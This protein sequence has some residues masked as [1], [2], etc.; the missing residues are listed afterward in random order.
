MVWGRISGFR[1][2]DEIYDHD[3][4]DKPGVYLFYRRLT[5]SVRYVGRSDSQIYTR[6][7]R[8]DYRF[9]RYKYCYDAEEAYYWECEYFHYFNDTIDN[10][11][12][13]ARPRYSDISCHWC[14]R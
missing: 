6:I 14:G 10:D 4:E 3:I 5:G 12:H 7:K 13:P 11:R 1:K 2:I 9:Y 8:R